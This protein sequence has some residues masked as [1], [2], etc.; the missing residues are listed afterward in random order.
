M[1][2]LID[3]SFPELFA[4]DGGATDPTDRRASPRLA[5]E[6][7]VLMAAAGRITRGVS[8]NLSSGGLCVWTYRALL[9]LTHVS[10]GFRLPNGNVLAAAIVRWSEG[11]RPGQLPRMGMAFLELHALDS[12]RLKRFCGARS[13]SYEEILHMVR[14]H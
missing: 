12:A 10:V 13:L 14:M 8:D 2:V 6:V 7:D 4:A 3:R 5:L 9:P 1:A 11:G